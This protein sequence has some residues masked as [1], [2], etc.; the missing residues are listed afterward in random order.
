[1]IYAQNIK[2]IRKHTHMQEHIDDEIKRSMAYLDIEA[3]WIKQDMELLRA[4]TH[5]ERPNMA[6]SRKVIYAYVCI[7]AS[8][9]ICI[10]ICKSDCPAL[11]LGMLR[12]SNQ[13]N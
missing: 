5:V 8:G 9:H 11:V 4:L 3:D 7:C 1:V 10:G 13:S 12:A 2:C 6:A